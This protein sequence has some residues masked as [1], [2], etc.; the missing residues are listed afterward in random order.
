MTCQ[1]DEKRPP[2]KVKDKTDLRKTIKASTNFERSDG[3]SPFRER[4]FRG[5]VTWKY[6]H[7]SAQPP[8]KVKDKT[9][10]RKTIKH[11]QI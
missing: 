5:E 1:S 9:D 8:I 10:L 4:R 3:K 6:F 11:Q 2:I 7:I